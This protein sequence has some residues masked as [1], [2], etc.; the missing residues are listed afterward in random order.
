MKMDLGVFKAGDEVFVKLGE[1]HET[2]LFLGN[3]YREQKTL[4]MMSVDTAE[5]EAR[6]SVNFW[7]KMGAVFA[8][9]QPDP[10]FNIQARTLSQ[11]PGL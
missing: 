7:T 10:A 11:S 3:A 1:S 8:C 2:N 9:C 5:V 4:N 6:M